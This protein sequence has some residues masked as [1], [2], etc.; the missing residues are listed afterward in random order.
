LP[1]EKVTKRK[2]TRATW[3]SGLP[4]APRSCR[5]FAN[6]LRSTAVTLLRDIIGLASM[7]KFRKLYVYAVGKADKHAKSFSAASAVLSKCQWK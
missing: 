5:D 7:K 1:K 6:S 3:P 4:C 2:G